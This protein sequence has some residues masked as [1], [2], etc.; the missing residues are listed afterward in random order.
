[1]R[2]WGMAWGA[3]CAALAVAAP[4]SASGVGLSGGHLAAAEWNVGDDN[5]YTDVFL[6]GVNDYLNGGSGLVDLFHIACTGDQ[7]LVSDYSTDSVTYDAQLPLT[8]ATVTA[9]AP[10]Q[11]VQWS[12]NTCDPTDEDDPAITTLPAL[13]IKASASISGGA[14]QE[15]YDDWGVGV[16]NDP[17]ACAIAAGSLARDASA[18]LSLSGAPSI[19]ATKLKFWAAVMESGAGGVVDAN[20]SSCWPAGG[21]AGRAASRSTPNIRTLVR[22]FERA[23][24][25]ARRRTTHSSSAHR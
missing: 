13:D 20:N 18:Q 5:T 22:R 24:R 17:G 2:L 21:S 7:L 9:A 25:H 19:D 16:G 14:P 6:L 10:L 3:L 4:A 15:P 12:W 11:G 1:M 23:R 8:S